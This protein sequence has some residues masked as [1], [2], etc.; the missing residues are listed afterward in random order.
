MK[1]IF[2]VDIENFTIA[3]VPVA[4]VRS[5]DA[6]KGDGRVLI[7]L[8]GGAFLWG[9]GSGGLVEAIPVAS[10]SKIP[11]ITVDYREGPENR[12][13]AATADVEKSSIPASF[14]M[15]SIRT[16]VLFGKLL[17]TAS[18]VAK[19]P[20]TLTPLPFRPPL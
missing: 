8:H 1:K 18:I 19:S 10:V 7:N 6:K 17:I 11:V 9:A 3:G 12:F 15:R 4:I 5:K 20:A 16:S 2:P 13:P 14:A